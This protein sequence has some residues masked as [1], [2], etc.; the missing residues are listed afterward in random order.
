MRVTERQVSLADIDGGEFVRG[1][2]ESRATYLARVLDQDV[3][4]AS[5]MDKVTKYAR[6][7]KR[8]DIFPPIFLNDELS[9][10]DGHHRCVAAGLAGCQAMH[11]VVIEGASGRAVDAISEILFA[12]SD[13]RVPGRSI[14][15]WE[16]P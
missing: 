14:G 1:K 10:L 16:R 5:D 2:R 8:G 15:G 3:Y 9:V 7:M 11:A 13:W 4:D 6:A 12:V